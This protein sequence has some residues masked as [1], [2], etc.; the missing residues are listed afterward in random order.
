MKIDQLTL[1]RIDVLRLVSEP[2][3]P[4]NGFA[5]GTEVTLVY[6]DRA[7]D[8]VLM[9]GRA[10]HP[11]RGV[12]KADCALL[13]S[14]CARNHPRLAWVC[15][16]S[17]SEVRVQV[18]SFLHSLALDE[19]RVAVDEKIVE[20]AR[21]LNASLKTPEAVVAWLR[22]DCLLPAP[23]GGVLVRALADVGGGRDA[24]EAFTLEGR[25][26]RAFVHR[27]PHPTSGHYLLVDRLTR[28]RGPKSASKLA[29]L[30]GAITF[31]DQTAAGQLRIDV[32]AQIAAIESTSTSTFLRS[33][34]RYEELENDA[35]LTRA[36]Q[37]GAI[38]YTHLESG[39]GGQL[40]FY[41]VE[42]TSADALGLGRNDRVEAATER[43][44]FLARKMTWAELHA[45]LAAAPRGRESFVGRFVE[46]RVRDGCV[47]LERDEHDAGEPP[48]QKGFLFQSLKGDKARI[49]RRAEARNRIHSA[50]CPI[51]HLAVLLE[52]GPARVANPGRLAALTT[53]VRKKVF[54]S[55]P[56][57]ARQEE[58]LYVALNTPDIALI[59]GP[60]GTGKTT[61]IVALVER[62]QE[63][64]GPGQKVLVTAFQHCAVENA[65]GRMRVNG[66][67]ALKFGE[68]HG[69]LENAE[70]IDLAIGRWC[71]EKAQTI[72][73]SV[74]PQS[75]PELVQRVGREL[76]AYLLAPP[77]LPRT[78][79]L[80]ERV[81]ADV[82][83]ALPGKTCDGLLALAAK[84]RD[85]A[86]ERPD[87][88]RERLLQRLRSLR[89]TPGGFADDGR[90]NAFL[91]LDELDRAAMLDPQARALL[92]RA[93][94][95]TNE[96]APPFLS[97]LAALRRRLSLAA[98][99]A[100]RSI[101]PNAREDVLGALTEVRDALD[102][103]FKESPDGA[104]AAVASYV[105]ALESDP[106][107]FR[108]AVLAYTPVVAATCQQSARKDVEQLDGQL[109]TVVVD[110]AARATPLDL[111]V[112]LARAHRRIVLVGDHRQLPHMLDHTL[113]RELEDAG[114]TEK[115]AGA[116][117]DELLR[118][119]LFERLFR[120]LKAREAQDGF[121]RTVTL[122]EQFRMHPALGEFV[123]RAFYPAN[124]SF[125]S[126][127]PP[128]DFVHGLPGGEGP[129]RWLEVGSAEGKEQPAGTSKK[130]LKEAE[131][132]AAELCRLMQ[133][134][135][136][137]RL[138]FGVISFYEKQVQCILQALAPAGLAE[139]DERGEWEVPFQVQERLQ[140]GTVDAFQGMEFDVVILSMVRSNA[141]PDGTEAE[142]RK[143]Y[144]HLMSPN[145]L[146]VA[147]SR[148]KRLLVVAGDSS[149]LASP[150]A[151]QAIGPLVEF[152]RTL[153]K[154]AP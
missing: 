147:M 154:G 23:G 104:S 96:G 58:A 60:P 79:E 106:N 66:L 101:E 130:R 132:I 69:G 29:L 57:T 56:P 43:P 25:C 153:C 4:A 18:H 36:R 109:D 143:K 19:V 87:P 120:D 110:E 134:E 59:Q 46:A 50:T 85:E 54:P 38:E 95:W 9:D 149:M 139:R 124:E 42:G 70:R 151:A 22:E 89:S 71:A 1:G 30:E 129:A 113:A 74:P 47:V 115:T 75:V 3:F 128:S 94:S 39:A 82:R 12:T 52:G 62:L 78:A 107:A 48:P 55:R 126:P 53:A 141:L 117:M 103:R 2:P 131:A 41:L 68:R 86:A 72:R 44:E 97:E 146:C 51:Q 67:P 133:S 121:P 11:V 8:P 28:S 61:V 26:V 92:E 63:L 122:N 123:S 105:S 7:A 40:L 64:L 127:R 6:P 116:R 83:S 33:W 102:G 81:A 114:A 14:L 140:V 80:L 91:A 148:Q 98:L 35:V 144:G 20:S 45:S 142:R 37:A 93:S 108:R 152:H 27:R 138:T 76:E 145:R 31:A 16:R 90:K 150:H 100:S 65:I 135:A 118:E 32:A 49:Q 24:A 5:R 17:G 34:E 77:T 15:D 119:S 21:K 88:R 84:L 125:R 112:P 111:F 73:K 13:E 137:E 10:G 136:G 99:P